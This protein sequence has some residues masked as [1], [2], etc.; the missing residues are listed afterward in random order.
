MIDYWDTGPSSAFAVKVVKQSNYYHPC[1]PDKESVL[2]STEKNAD[3][4]SSVLEV[5]KKKAPSSETRKIFHFKFTSWDLYPPAPDVFVE[6]VDKVKLVT[7][8]PTFG[9]GGHKS[10]SDSPN[11]SSKNP[12]PIVVHD[13]MGIGRSGV[14]VAVDYLVA[15]TTQQKMRC[16]I[17]IAKLVLELR[18][19]RANT[20]QL[21]GQYEFIYRCLHC[22][23]N[24]LQ[25]VLDTERL[26]RAKGH[27]YTNVGGNIS[28]AISL[29]SVTSQLATHSQRPH[30]SP[31]LASFPRALNSLASH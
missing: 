27:D 21:S 9:T 2:Q 5:T 8:T 28:P 11:H 29:N 16:H 22:H 24:R 20:V 15:F 30:H 12:F 26:A 3:W 18:S 17:D 13:L 19:Q 7:E 4:V 6:F 1:E 23:L 31:N 10:G 25:L 14:F